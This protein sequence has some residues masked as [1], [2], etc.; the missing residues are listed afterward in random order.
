MGWRRFVVFW[1]SAPNSP[2]PTRRLKRR[3]RTK[4]VPLSSKWNPKGS[5]SV[6][7]QLLRQNWSVTTPI[8]T[9]PRVRVG[10]S[11]CL[12]GGGNQSGSSRDSTFSHLRRWLFLI[13]ATSSSNITIIFSTMGMGVFFLVI[14]VAVSSTAANLAHAI[15]METKGVLRNICND[16]SISGRTAAR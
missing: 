9:M 4:P 14:G 5:Q 6:F 1:K 8:I 2:M 11:Q 10:S 16:K 3:I 12:G 7:K 13:T 15:T